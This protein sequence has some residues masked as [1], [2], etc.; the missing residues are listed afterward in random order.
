LTLPAAKYQGLPPRTQFWHSLLGRIR[1]LPGVTSAGTVS[2]LPMNGLGSATSFEVVGQ[3]KPPLGQGPS[4]TIKVIDGD[5]FTV[6]GIPLLRGRLFSEREQQTENHYAVVSDTLARQMFPNQ[7]PIG[8]RL[9]VSWNDTGPDEIIGVVGDTKMVS[10]DEQISPAIYYPYSRTPYTSE[11]VVVRTAGN[12]AAVASS[13][14]QAV[15]EIDPDLPV[16]HLRSMEDVIARSLAQ[17]RIVMLLLAVFAAVALVLA[18]VGIYGVMSYMVSQRTQEIGIR[19]ALGADRGGV[20]AMVLTHALRLAVIGLAAGCAAA[21]ALTG[22][23]RTMLYDVTPTDPMTFAGVAAILLAVAAVATAVP[24]MRATR[25][26]PLTALK[27]E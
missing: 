15:R 22:L 12:P 9:L 4:A 20:I 23:L 16:S 5:Y 18:T 7:N 13:L 10:I 6:L 2:F 25:I 1:N 19:M 17:R 21:F 24:A 11:T 14:V 26:D 3:P 8:Q 27:A